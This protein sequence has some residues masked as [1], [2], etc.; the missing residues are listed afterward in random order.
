LVLSRRSQWGKDGP[1]LQ[2]QSAQ[3]WLGDSVGEM[4]CYYALADA[5]LLGG[6]FA[7]LGGQ[8]LIEAAACGCPLV[9]GPHTF[10]FTQAAELALAAGAALRVTDIVHGMQQA[11]ALLGGTQR[12]SHALQALAFAQAHRGAAQRMAL[13]ITA[14]VRA[15]TARL[16]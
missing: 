5:A 6:S 13:K 3:V 1:G 8:N 2:D 9:M 15:K 10:N 14:R 12:Q 4:A 16:P 7:P 11:C